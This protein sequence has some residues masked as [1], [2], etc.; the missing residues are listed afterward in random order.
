MLMIYLVFAVMATLLVIIY[1]MRSELPFVKGKRRL[2]S[3]TKFIYGCA[4]FVFLFSF[5]ARSEV[6][7]PVL[8]KPASTPTPVAAPVSEDVKGFNT[9]FLDFKDRGIV[10]KEFDPSAAGI[11]QKDGIKQMNGSNADCSMT[12]SVYQD[13]QTGTIKAYRLYTVG[14]TTPAMKALIKDVL[15]AWTEGAKWLDVNLQY[16]DQ[17]STKFKDAIIDLSTNELSDE[18]AYLLQIYPHGYENL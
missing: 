7:K 5:G 1:R 8:D 9:V 16:E 14:L 3:H 13:S 4:I 17:V 12:L 18:P 6:Y 10:L 11:E 15:P 2:R